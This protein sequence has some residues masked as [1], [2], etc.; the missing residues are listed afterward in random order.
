MENINSKD[1]KTN[2]YVLDIVKERE[3]AFKILKRKKRWL[4]HILRGESL[5]KKVIEGQMEGKR[6]NP[7]IMLLDDIKANEVH[8][9]SKRKALYRESCRN[10]M[11]RTCFRA[12]HQL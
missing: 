6:G 5:V 2:E 7:R 9:M 11:P 4:G 12:E 10:W 8:E 3:K 1:H